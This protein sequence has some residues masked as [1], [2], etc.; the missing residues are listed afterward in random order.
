M[1]VETDILL[2]QRDERGV[3]TVT[4]NRPDV[5]NAFGAELMGAIAGTF[6]ELAVDDTVRCVVLTGAGAAFSAGAD[7][8]WMRAMAGYSYDENVADSRRLDALFRAITRFPAPVVAR[9]N[10]HALGGAMGLIACADIAVAVRGAKLGFTEARLGLA[11]AV[12]STYVQPKI[13]V[14][15]AR[16]YFLTGEIFDADRAYDLGLVHEVCDPDDLDEVT[17]RIVGLVLTAGP[18]AQREIKALIPEVAA[19]ATLDASAD[20][21]VDVISRLRVSD[22]GQAGIRAFFDKRPAPWVPEG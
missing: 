4:L 20:L 3:V 14:S 1:S 10:G 15:N 8:T 22:E 19:A 6:D 7:L 5:R 2:R 17:D 12:V 18:V 16:R 21:T 9:V 11:P 13:G